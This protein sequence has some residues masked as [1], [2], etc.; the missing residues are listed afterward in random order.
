MVT[1]TLSRGVVLFWRLLYTEHIYNSTLC[2]EVCPLRVSLIEGSTVL[3]L[4]SV[5]KEL[6]FFF[7]LRLTEITRFDSMRVKDIY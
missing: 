7:K 4:D 6:S 1:A 2:M 3:S 5:Q